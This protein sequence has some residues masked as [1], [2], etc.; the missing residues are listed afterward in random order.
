MNK[1]ILHS[2]KISSPFSLRT[3]N[4]LYFKRQKYWL[5]SA[6][7]VSRFAKTTEKLPFSPLFRF[8]W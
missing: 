2:Q 4:A 3:S 8:A 5:K 1:T 6:K 7:P